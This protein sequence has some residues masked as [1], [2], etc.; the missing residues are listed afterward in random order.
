MSVIDM[1]SLRAGVLFLASALS[2]FLPRPSEAGAAFLRN[3]PADFPRFEIKGHPEEGRLLRDLFYR[4]F[5]PV[6]PAATLWDE[7]LTQSSLWVPARKKPDLWV[8]WKKTLLSRFI[9][10]EGYVATHQHASI[11]HQDGWPF[12]FWKQAQGTWGWHFSLKGVPKGWHG[13]EVRSEKPWKVQGAESRGVRND[14]WELV[15]KEPVV[16]ITSPP[17]RLEAFVS[18]FLQLRW[19]SGDLQSSRIYLRWRRKGEP[20]FG[21]DR[22]MAVPPPGPRAGM[23][24]PAPARLPDVSIAMVPVW[25]HPMWRGTVVQLQLLV[26]GAPAGSVLGLQAVFSQFDT[27]H[28]INNQDFILGSDWYFRWTGD[29]DFLRRIANRMR[30]ALRY[31]LTVCRVSE[32]KVVVVPFPGHDGRAGWHLDSK[33][34]KVFHWGHGIGSNYWDLLPFGNRDAYATILLY[35]TLLRMAELEEAIAENPSWNVPRGALSFDPKRLRTLAA[36]VKER[37]NKLFWN[38]ETGRFVACIDADGKTHDFGYTFLNL[39]AVHYGIATD[40]KARAILDWIEGKRIV[41][42]DT[43]TGADIYHF[44]FAPR[45]TTKRNISWYFWAWSA[46]E[47]IPFGGQVQDGGAVLGFSFHDLSA[48]LA[49]R[50][51]ANA[52]HRLEEILSWYRDVLRAGGYR[53]YYADGTRGTL[54]GGGRPGGL[55]ID[56]EFIE[57]ILV[58][59][60]MLYG[61]AGFEPTPAGISL[62]P[63]LPETIP[64]LEIRPIRYRNLILS[65]KVRKHSVRV[66]W[67]GSCVEPL[68]L[69]L[70]PGRWSCSPKGGQVRVKRISPSSFTFLPLGPGEI[71][72]SR[73]GES[74]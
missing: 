50:G 34:R 67:Q 10:S 19:R 65:V 31:L 30:V 49:V 44:R 38:P 21:A 53:R 3:I 18:P 45:A 6:G 48:R 52:W 39:E 73:T 55:G 43:S 20:D 1:P 66:A 33:G 24:G 14:V 41:E 28:S 29:L 25:R 23:F 51:P 5:L 46:P 7:W 27:R 17:M 54:Q 57:S 72:C 32:E 36:E 47:A 61:F 13:T 59:Q 56:K 22:Q 40:S 12:P 26:V 68:T 4:H 16:R 35:R 62:K 2:A 37:F 15:L 63:S 71:A 69:S 8:R 11:A 74:R 9:D 70:P 42:G 60:I 64:E 58:P